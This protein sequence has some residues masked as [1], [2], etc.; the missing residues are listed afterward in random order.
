M[1]YVEIKVSVPAAMREQAEA[2]AIMIAENGIYTED[3]GD[4]AT[5]APKIGHVDFISDKLLRAGGTHSIIHIYLSQKA[6]AQAAVDF[7]DERLRECG[8]PHV[9]SSENVAGAD[10]ENEWKKYYKP[11]KTG[12]NL[13]ICPS[14]LECEGG[15]RTVIKMDP[16]EAFGSGTHET[17]R[18]ALE[19]LET[20]VHGGERVLDMGCGSGILSVAALVLGAGSAVAADITAEALAAT[21]ENARINGVES[22]VSAVMASE[23]LPESEYDIIAANIVAD[24]IANYAK[25]FYSS[26]KAGGLLVASGIIAPREGELARTLRSCGFTVER[27]TEMGGWVGL[28]AKK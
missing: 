22:R 23:A 4:V 17:T 3:Y 14:W 20:A 9:F 10:W 21:A 18:I 11:V 5:A 15:G 7:L 28:I 8:V 13:I 25:A 2:A 19:L 16:G 6:D 26:L 27:R 12:S 24:I 1:D